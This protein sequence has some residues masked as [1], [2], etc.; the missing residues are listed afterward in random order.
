M[1]R[2][3]LNLLFAFLFICPVNAQEKDLSGIKILFQGRVI[4]GQSLTPLPGSQVLVNRRFTSVS[5]DKGNVALYV[6]V[7]DTLVFTRTGY[8]PAEIII[9]DTLVGKPFVAGIFLNADT[10]EIGEVVIVPRMLR[11]RSELMN[12]VTSTP[13]EIENA[14][15]NVAMSAYQGR[16]TTGKLG[17][18]ASNYELLRQRQRTDAYEKGGIPSD[19]IAGL[20]P[21]MLLPA[22]YLLMNG[23][24]EKP[25]PLRQGI[26]DR[27]LDEIMQRYL[28]KK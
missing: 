6:N 15:N 16:T 5:D 11:I 25:S 14:R 8:K 4:D 10:I 12:P 13:P 3:T 23:L 1:K 26:S 19:R 2:S 27:E 24:P 20:S 21:F 18:P 17:D 22:A 28:K 9:R 7:S